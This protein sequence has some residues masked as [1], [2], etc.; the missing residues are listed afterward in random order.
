MA[1]LVPKLDMF[2]S[3]RPAGDATKNIGMPQ[4]FL[5]V[6]Q[7]TRPA[8]DATQ[9]LLRSFFEWQVSIHASRGGRDPLEISKLGSVVTFQ[10]TRPAG[11]ATQHTGRCHKRSRGFNPRVPR[12]TRRCK[13]VQSDDFFYV[14]IHAS[15]GGRDSCRTASGVCSSS[16]NPRVPRGTR[17]NMPKNSHNLS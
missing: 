14:S 12:G 4:T 2:Q 7:S 1:L 10:S 16:F 11:D 3:T 6:F 15:R 13:L 17:L 9:A 8:G 5:S